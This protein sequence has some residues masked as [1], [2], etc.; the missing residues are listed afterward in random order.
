MA[1]G[2]AASFVD[3]AK[4]QSV[5]NG[6]SPSPTSLPE[7]VFHDLDKRISADSCDVVIPVS[8]KLTIYPALPMRHEADQSVG[9]LSSV[10][11]IVETARPLSKVIPLL[12]R[13]LHVASIQISGVDH[14]FELNRHDDH[15]LKF[16]GEAR[17]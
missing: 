17:S 14:R 11:L 15:L 16:Q 8:F 13:C 1:E 12:N 7:A 3:F 9:P 6:E 2:M 4:N 10:G 5:E